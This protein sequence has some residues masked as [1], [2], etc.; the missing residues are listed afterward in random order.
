MLFVYSV[1]NQINL[2]FVWDFL[3]KLI[4][5]F[6]IANF[7]MLV[8]IYIQSVTFNHLCLF[9]LLFSFIFSFKLGLCKN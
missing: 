4:K 9:Y 5:Y 1:F 8:H 6:E 7:W 3:K 2:P